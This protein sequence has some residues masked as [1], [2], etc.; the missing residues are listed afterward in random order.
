MVMT[1]FVVSD[2][3]GETA[4]RVARSALAQFQDAPVVIVR[5]GH[6]QTREQVGAVVHEAATRDSLIIHTLVSDE[7]RQVMLDESRR[8]GVEALD[9]MGPVLDRVATQLAL[10]P[11]EKPGLFDQLLQASSRRIE[12]V[13]F[14]FRHDDGQRADEL[15]QAE[16]VLVGVSRSMKTPTMVYLAYRGW[17]AA[18]V[19]LVP[20]VGVPD[21]LL[22]VPKER[23][24]GLFMTPARLAELRRV[25]AHHLRMGNTSYVSMEDVREELM[26]AQMLCID[27]GWKRIDVTG[28]SVEE[29]ALEILALVPPADHP[30]EDAGAGAPRQP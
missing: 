21:G 17:F 15:P 10:T 19:P 5:R 20:G 24:F 18:N 25:R 30:D 16:I 9:L 12:A 13:E 29:V 7:M 8:H 27:H 14:A 23:V 26:R 22:N 2:S 28:K 11:Q 4:E 1:I 6:V 3:T